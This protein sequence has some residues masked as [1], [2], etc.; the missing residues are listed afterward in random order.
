MRTHYY[1]RSGKKEFAPLKPGDQVR[2]EPEAG[3]KLWRQATVV[4]HHTTPRSYIVNTGTQI[5]RRNRVALRCD[6]GGPKR[7]TESIGKRI[8]DGDHQPANHQAQ[9]NHRSSPTPSQE[10]QNSKDKAPPQTTLE[11]YRNKTRHQLSNQMSAA[12]KDEGSQDHYITRSGR[13]SR[14]PAKLNI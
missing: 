8:T 12:N 13:I 11:T 10:E 14:K 6:L 3:S 2:I 5:L 7:S 1:N 4:G 9:V